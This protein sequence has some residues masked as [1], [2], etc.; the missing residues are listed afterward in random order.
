VW[1]F[2]NVDC[3]YPDH[4]ITVTSPFDFEEGYCEFFDVLTSRHWVLKGIMLMAHFV[5]TTLMIDTL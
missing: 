4:Y 3:V 2:S 1:V 5:E